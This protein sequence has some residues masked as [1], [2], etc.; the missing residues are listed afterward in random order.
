MSVCISQ[1]IATLRSGRVVCRTLPEPRLC[2]SADGGAALHAG[3]SAVVAKVTLG[4]DPRPWALKCYTRPKERL[5]QIYAGDF[6]AA[7]IY[8][9]DISGRGEWADVVV[10]EWIEGVTLDSAMR[11]AVDMAD[12]ARLTELSRRFDRMAADLLGSER[13]H[14]DLKPENIL[15]S[16]ECMH[17]VDWDAAWLPALEGYM[18]VETGTPDWQHPLRTAA[19]YDKSIDDYSVALVSTMAAALAADC[20][21]LA[22]RLDAGGRL[23]SPTAA[24]GG[25]DKTLDRAE[26]I[27]ACRGDAVHYRIARLLH[28]PTP[29]LP[30]LPELL[31][32]AVS[33]VGGEADFTDAELARS[34][35]TGRWGYM[36]RGEWITPPLYD[37]GFEPSEGVALVEIGRCRHFITADM[38][39]VVECSAFDSVKPMRGGRAVAVKDGRRYTIRPDGSIERA[40]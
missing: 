21:A 12:T 29:R 24:V 28:S 16:G 20:R 14:G 17:L 1:I 25:T 13:A 10:R 37:V 7:E 33:R 2:L 39:P 5:A 32:Y 19:L 26:D 40:F 36:R 23:F 34:S 9:Y 4:D 22:P 38:R 3:N 11:E 31:S 18:A 27:L 30:L 8:V 35:T 15:L 6:Y